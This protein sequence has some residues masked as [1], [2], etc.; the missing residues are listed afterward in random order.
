MLMKII[1]P[2]IHILLCDL[3]SFFLTVIGSFSLGISGWM[4]TDHHGP[5][6][7][8]WYHW[9]CQ[10]CFGYIHVAQ[11]GCEN[12]G[13][14]LRRYVGHYNKE[15]SILED[16]QRNLLTTII[17]GKTA[18]LKQVNHIDI[19]HYEIDQITFDVLTDKMIKS[20]F[21]EN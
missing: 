14:L 21:I 10:N 12:V 20:N 17:Q 11:S 16:P 5:A 8:V 3:Q 13:K 9:S 19:I 4:E 7:L 18:S 6:D 15:C 2:C 1:L